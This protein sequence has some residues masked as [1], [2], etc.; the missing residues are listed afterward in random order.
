[1]EK[2]SIA[3]L[4]VEADYHFKRMKTNMPRYLADWDGEPDLKI[5][6][7]KNESLGLQDGNPHLTADDCEYMLAAKQFY[8][9]IV[10]HDAVML[11]ASAIVMDGV[12]YLFSARSGTGKSTHTQLWLKLFGTD[13][14][15]ILNDDK[16]AIRIIDG[17]AYACGTPFSGKSD[18]NVNKVVPLKA[19]CFIERSENNFIEKMGVHKALPNIMN[20]T[21]HSANE[22]YLQKSLHIIEKI[23]EL[24][25]IY[26]LGCNISTDA[27]QLAHDVMS[28]EREI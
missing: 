28:G 3:G 1:M 21:I 24:T 12:A 15:Y 20:Q 25:P 22:D 16:P 23:I 18:L 8:H 9:Q 26:R 6:V 10:D 14:A 5:N 2:Y 13:R 7:P 11:H 19:I 17:A 27:A 4:K